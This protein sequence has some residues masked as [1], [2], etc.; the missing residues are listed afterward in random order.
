MLQ[1]FRTEFDRSFDQIEKTLDQI[2]ED[3]HTSI[4]G[5]EGN[6]ISIILRHLIGN[7]KS[8][9]TG[10]LTEDGEKPWRDRDRE[11]EPSSLGKEPMRAELREA[12]AL[13]MA[14]LDQLADGDFGRNVSIR[15]QLLTVHEALVRSVCHT[16]FHAGQI[17]FLGKTH[18]GKQW[19]TLSIPR[20][21]SSAYNRNPT[22]EKGMR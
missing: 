8:R 16:V 7:L 2:D 13:V 9:F 22:K 15:G 12:R 11:F 10:F 5:E 1:S 14:E 4:L 18:L 20:G 17:V 21:K 3:Q 19:K 6:S